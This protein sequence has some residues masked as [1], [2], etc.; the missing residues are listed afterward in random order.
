MK[1]INTPGQL[2]RA[3]IAK[4]KP[5]QIIGTFLP[6][7]NPAYLHVILNELRQA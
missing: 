6:K 3:A 1:N 5:L 7:L 2:F 4:E